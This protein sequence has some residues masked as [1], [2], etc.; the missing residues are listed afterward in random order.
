MN[1]RRANSPVRYCPNC[2]KVV[3]QKIAVNQ[4][5]EEAHARK[6]REMRKFCVDCGEQLIG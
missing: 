1:H 2:G 5:S 4:C 3:N 6:R